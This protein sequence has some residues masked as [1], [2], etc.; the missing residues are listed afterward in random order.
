[1]EWGSSVSQVPSVAMLI[2]FLILDLCREGVK[3]AL[4]M[5]AAKD[6][7]IQPEI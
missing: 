1:M 6:I 2:E 3:E 7:A 4:P 5:S